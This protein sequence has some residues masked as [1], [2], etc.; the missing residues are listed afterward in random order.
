MR[1]GVGRDREMDAECKLCIVGVS[2]ASSAPFKS[3]VK[4]AMTR[5]LE[6]PGH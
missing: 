6:V 1:D 2:L 5:C 4:G 3:N